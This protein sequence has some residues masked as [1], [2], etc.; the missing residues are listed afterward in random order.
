M[1]KQKAVRKA[2]ALALI[3]K[4]EDD[5]W[6]MFVQW[7][8]SGIMQ[9]YYGPDKII[10]L[11]RGGVSTYKSTTRSGLED[12]EDKVIDE[13]EDNF[14][15]WA[16]RINDFKN[17]QPLFD[18]YWTVIPY[19]SGDAPT[20]SAKD[21]WVWKVRFGDNPQMQEWVESKVPNAAI[22][23]DGYTF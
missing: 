3:L 1:N 10:N 13:M 12:S 2:I 15:Y 7:L 6:N 5:Y 11:S 22:P 14:S 4:I 23:D 8:A 17:G 18:E 16:N 19:N 9:E 20:D 21:D